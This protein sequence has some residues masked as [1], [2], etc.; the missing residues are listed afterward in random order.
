[1]V[2][3]LAASL[4]LLLSGLCHAD[5]GIDA[6]L[7][8]TTPWL[9]EEIVLSVEVMDD[10][11]IIEQIMPPWTPAGVMI[12]PLTG[13]QE[14]LKTAD[15]IRILHRH[16]WAVMP[17]Y[18]GPL[19]LQP[20]EVEARVA[21]GGR[22]TLT[23]PAL[24]IETRP[25][26]PLIPVDIP[27]SPL[28]IETQPVPDAIPRDRPLNWVITVEGQG[29]ST[30][31]LRHWLDEALR[32]TGSLRVYPPDMRLEDGITPENPLLQRVVARIV[33][34]PRESGHAR[35]PELVLP[36]VDPVDG[37][38]HLARLAGSEIRVMHPL[39]LAVRPWLPWGVGSLLLA[40]AF[41][42]ARPHWRRERQRRTWAE[43]LRHAETPPALRKAWHK[44]GF[45]PSDDKTM[46]LLE[47][48]DAACYG[49]KPLS[50]AE[51]NR[52]K[53]SLLDTLR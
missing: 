10:R 35:L 43:A 11:T 32:D 47:R 16:R 40:L 37:Q 36:Y 42:I 27:V 15:G 21:G 44:G 22:I 25:L 41:W 48:L 7:S 53:Q 29:I 19:D 14:R 39:W 13:Q 4:G 6:Q 34:E 50:E 30:R 8:N 9:R 52:L 5:L 20:P 49:L 18:A 31:G 26:D 2:R 12:R 46:A 45:G 28:R 17:L 24:H 38:V 1:M 3:L 33:L 23:P 51:F